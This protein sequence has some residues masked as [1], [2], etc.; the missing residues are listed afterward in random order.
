MT[1]RAARKLPPTSQAAQPSALRT[2]AKRAKAAAVANLALVDAVVETLEDAEDLRDALEV[3]AR[4]ARGREK[5]KSF[6]EVRRKLKI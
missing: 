2:I 4:I 3:R 6:A 5:V 1:A